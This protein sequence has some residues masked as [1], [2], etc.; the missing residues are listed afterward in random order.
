VFVEN[1]EFP[2]LLPGEKLVKEERNNNEEGG[3]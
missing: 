2:G 3:V 1:D